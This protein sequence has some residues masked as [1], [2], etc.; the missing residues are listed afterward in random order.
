M[1]TGSIVLYGTSRIDSSD[2]I[3]IAAD[4]TGAKPVWF[5]V[6]KKYESYID[7]Q[8]SDAF[9]LIY[10]WIA[11]EQGKSLIVNS[12]VSEKLSKNLSDNIVGI[13]K[14][15]CPTLSANLTLTFNELTRTTS[16]E[17]NHKST[18]FSGGIDSLYTVYKNKPIEP[19]STLLFTNTGQHGNKRTR[20]IF[21]SRA[22]VAKSCLNDELIPFIT[23]NTNLD[24]IF[25]NNFIQ[26]HTLRNASCALF[27]QN[28]ISKFGYSAGLLDSIDKENIKPNNDMASI[29]SF[30]LPLFSTERLSFYGE[31]GDKD[32][33]QKL[34]KVVSD[35][36]FSEKIYVCTEKLLPTDNCCYCFKCRRTMVALD[37]LG[38]KDVLNNNFHSFYGK[39]IRIRI[40]I[41]MI[42]ALLV[43]AKTKVADRETAMLCYNNMGVKK[44]PVNIVVSILALLKSK[45]PESIAWRVRNKYPYLW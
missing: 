29:D 7:T 1:D 2:L 22:N 8:S 15:L 18:G 21:V 39:R 36:N 6:P 17:L 16:Q 40:R 14:S 41:R 9:A 3:R 28:G 33:N 32:R 27:L 4:V 25:E 38:Y 26:T 23:V 20:E 12:A 42:L 31:G 45:M 11:M 34:I 44:Y 24:T 13:F 43:N 10:T 30:I 37:A 5:E 35:P 19:Y